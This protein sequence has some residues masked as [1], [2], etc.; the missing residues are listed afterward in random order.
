[1]IGRARTTT[2]SQL[3]C[4]IEPV[5][6]SYPTSRKLIKDMLLRRDS[7]IQVIFMNVPSNNP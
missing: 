4:Y 2:L 6:N 1:M 3:H 5:K 7:K